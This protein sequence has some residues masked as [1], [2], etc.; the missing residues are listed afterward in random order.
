MSAVVAQGVATATQRG[1]AT[2]IEITINGR[3]LARQSTGV[4]RFAAELVSA[5]SSRHGDTRAA[6]IVAPPGATLP[7][8]LGNLTLQPRGR[9]DGH[10]WEQLELPRYWPDEVLINLCNTGPLFRKRQ[11]VVLHDAAVMTNP[12]AYSVAF[13]TWYRALFSGLMRH[14]AVV[15]SVSEFSAAEL[16]RHVGVRAAGIEVIYE[17]GEHVLRSPSD[18]SVLERL[19]LRGEKYV[20]AVGSRTVN[21]NFAGVVKAATLLTDLGVKLVAAG[22][23]NSRVFSGVDLRGDN[24]VLAGYVTDGELRALYENAQCFVFPSFYEGFGL[25]PLEAMHCGCPVIVSRRASLPEVCADAAV[26]CDPADPVDIA[27]C[28]RRVLTSAGL[29]SELRAAGLERAGHFTWSKAA[30]R[31]E[32]LI[33]THFDGWST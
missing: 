26:Y 30:D 6:R 20:L 1:A 22:G 25:P 21:K 4:D 32:H 16:M 18:S 9:L 7:A 29:R 31:L 2:P 14:A 19:G 15:A 5:W 8:A 3:F 12:A 28:M 33:A 17:S 23:T 13:R 10:L 27:N 24:I 11:L